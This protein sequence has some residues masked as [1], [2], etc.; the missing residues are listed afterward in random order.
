MP[1][2][3]IEQEYQT[4]YFW[5]LDVISCELDEQFSLD[6]N[7]G[8]KSYRLLEKSLLTSKVNKFYFESLNEP[9]SVYK[10]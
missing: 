3:D 1:G 2:N 8:L 6:R 9:V 7:P 10:K 4:R 5:F